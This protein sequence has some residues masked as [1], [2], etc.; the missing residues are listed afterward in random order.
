[1]YTIFGKVID[2]WDTLDLIEKEPTDAKDRPLNEVTI[3][4]VT[5]HAN[6]I[7]ENEQ[8]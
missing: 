5:I 2:G 1:M 8:A 6:P 3:H 7:A 4:T